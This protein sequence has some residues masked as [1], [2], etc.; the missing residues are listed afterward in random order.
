[1]PTQGELKFEEL[2]WEPGCS[3]T[4][5]SLILYTEEEKEFRRDFNTIVGTSFYQKQTNSTQRIQLTKRH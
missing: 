5:K 3:L 2:G 1:M 4:E